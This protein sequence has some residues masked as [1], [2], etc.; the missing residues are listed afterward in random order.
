M[1][2]EDLSLE[3]LFSFSKGLV[4]LHGRR[5]LI[6]D[7]HAIGQ[8][9]RDLV[10][11]VG[12]NPARRILTRLGYFWGQADA[13]AMKRIFSWDNTEELLKAA[14]VLLM[15][16]G[17]ARAELRIVELDSDKGRCRLEFIWRDSGEADDYVKEA[18]LSDQ[19]CCWKLAG[20]ASG[21]A[22]YALGRDVYFI[23]K[24]CRAAGDEVCLG[25]GRDLE[26]WGNE[27]EPHLEYFQAEDIQG[28]I[29]TL[30][31]QLRFKDE[32]LAHQRKQL[33]KA[34]RGPAIFPVE[35]RNQRFI[36]ILNLAG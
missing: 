17:A 10:E 32:E 6:Q 15:F 20:Y 36:H 12:L 22:S 29:R 35:V 21:Y 24:N 25:V 33:E 8:F 13:S 23:E 14:P 9:R 28:K 1:K 3:E 16:Q 5:V 31:E 18:G 30:T 34:L 19:A 7:L 27:I 11:M 26:S 4:D 2:A